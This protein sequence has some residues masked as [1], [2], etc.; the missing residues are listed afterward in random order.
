MLNT[1]GQDDGLADSRVGFLGT[2]SDLLDVGQI[3]LDT[4]V[5]ATPKI[6]IIG[7]PNMDALAQLWAAVADFEAAHPMVMMEA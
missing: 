5:S 1:K 6:E 4:E 3:L 7:V 2:G